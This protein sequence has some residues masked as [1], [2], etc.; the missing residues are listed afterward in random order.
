MLTLVFGP[1]VGLCG[2]PAS[3]VAGTPKHCAM[4]QA[5]GRSGASCC[6]DDPCGA[7]S[8]DHAPGRMPENCPQ[9]NSADAH[10]PP[11]S[12]ASLDRS[13]AFSVAWPVLPAAFQPEAVRAARS[14]WPVAYRPLIPPEAKSS[15]LAQ[16][17]ALNT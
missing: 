5:S 2:A 15:L 9:A 3:A 7:E 6:C 4:N 17:C 16:R 10:C 1:L 14:P 12:R 8:K 11:V 13:Q